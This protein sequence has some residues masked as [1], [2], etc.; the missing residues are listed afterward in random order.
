MAAVVVGGRAVSVCGSVRI[1]DRADEAGVETH[2]DFRG[3][4]HALA[5]VWAWAQAVRNSGR[6]PLY[7]T[8]WSNMQSRRVAEK[9]GLVQ[10]GTVVHVT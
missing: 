2:P 1:S 10:Y 7:S 9:L 3:R 6:V 5:A 4:G 8:S